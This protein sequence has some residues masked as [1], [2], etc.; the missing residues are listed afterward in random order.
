VWQYF[1]N[2]GVGEFAGFFGEGEVAGVFEPDEEFGG[3]VDFVEEGFGCG[4]GGVG[5]VAALVGGNGVKI[6]A[7]ETGASEL[8]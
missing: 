8:A 3:G 5:I 4:G 2:Q 1:L 6:S 7:C